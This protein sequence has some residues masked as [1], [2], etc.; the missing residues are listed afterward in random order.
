VVWIARKVGEDDESYGGV[1]VAGMGV[2]RPDDG[3]GVLGGPGDTPASNR[4]QLR[5]AQGKLG[6]GLDQLP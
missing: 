4:A 2:S 5:V 3:E 6:A 1:R